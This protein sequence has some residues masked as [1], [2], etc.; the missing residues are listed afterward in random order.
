MEIIIIYLPIRVV[1]RIQYV[2][3]Y[4]VLTAQPGIRW[5]HNKWLP[6][7]LFACINSLKEMPFV[8]NYIQ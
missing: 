5:V 4:K 7:L 2:T 8:F 6:L 3:S 1:I